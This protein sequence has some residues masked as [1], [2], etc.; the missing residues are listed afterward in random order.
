[1]LKPVILCALPQSEH[2]NCDS[3]L[4]FS[5]P[6]KNCAIAKQQELEKYRDRRSAHFEETIFRRRYKVNRVPDLIMNGIGM[7]LYKSL[8]L[9]LFLKELLIVSNCEHPL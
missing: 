7:F 2:E 6:H 1:M 5:I 8:T 3:Y 9:C 4:V